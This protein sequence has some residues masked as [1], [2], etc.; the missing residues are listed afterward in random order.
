MGKMIKILMLTA[1]LA[2]QGWQQLMYSIRL[3]IP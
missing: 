1:A 3:A 2:L